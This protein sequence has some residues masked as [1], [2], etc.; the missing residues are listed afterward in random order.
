MFLSLEF[1]DQSIAGNCMVLSD[2][3]LDSD[4]IVMENSKT[5]EE[6]KKVMKSRKEDI[7]AELENVR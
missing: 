3:T 6:M 7:Q 1:R 5:P 4:N 2:N